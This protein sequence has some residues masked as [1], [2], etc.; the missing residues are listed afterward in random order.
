M[1]LLINLNH[2]IMKKLILILL[3][4]LINTQIS[5][6]IPHL[7]WKRGPY[8]M[9]GND[10]DI[11]SICFG[12]DLSIFMTGKKVENSGMKFAG[13][14]KVNSSGAETFTRLDD[15]N[16]TV[17]TGCILL[18]SSVVYT[19]KNTVTYL[20]FRTKDSGNFISRIQ[21]LPFANSVSLERWGDTIVA[22]LGEGSGISLYD[23]QGN[24]KRSFSAGYSLKGNITAR[25]SG[26][27]LWIFS[28]R[29]NPDFRGA[30]S[31]YNLVNGQLLWTGEIDSTVKSFGDIDSSGNSYLASSCIYTS[32]GSMYLRIK[33][34]D[35]NGT[36]I[37]DKQ[38]LVNK[39][40]AANY[41]NWVNSVAVNW[42]KGLV[43]VGCQV[44]RDSVLNT[45]RDAGYVL[46]RKISNGDSAF[47]FKVYGDEIATMN[48]V[49]DV[50]FNNLNEMVLLIKSREI[51]SSPRNKFYSI[52]YIIDT[53]TGV[54]PISGETPKEHKLSQNYPNPFNP[55]TKINFSL[56]K[57]SYVLLVVYDMLGKEVTTLLNEVKIPRSY[58]VD[59]NGSNLSSGTYFYRMT[60]D[61]Y[62]E[63]KKMTLVK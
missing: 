30:V 58:S 1:S 50:K 5:A 32:G 2:I 54:T 28:G 22:V 7:Q 41:E 46:G 60:A 59:F 63:T 27:N 25:I 11:Y 49:Q 53:L 43:V 3:A 19:F 61:D 34:F 45:S 57:R 8:T 24:L 35:P 12:P 21:I 16:T 26:N 17:N 38:S 15:T 44:E 42:K 39:T 37:W 10:D 36:L 52:N 62:T 13:I 56:P 48:F 18:S 31:K 33:K 14:K 9:G 51:S 47:A 29:Y 23:N 55:A 20:V 40:S 6:Q 4:F